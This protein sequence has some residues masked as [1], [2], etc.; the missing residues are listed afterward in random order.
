MHILGWIIWKSSYVEPFIV[1]STVP[2]FLF[3][4]L[5]IAGSYFLF[6]SS[7]CGD[8]GEVETEDEGKSSCGK[9]RAVLAALLVVAVCQNTASEIQILAKVPKTGFSNLRNIFRP[10]VR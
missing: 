4:G 2:D 1:L 6:F 8:L 3:R 10:P 7:W 5:I 9:L